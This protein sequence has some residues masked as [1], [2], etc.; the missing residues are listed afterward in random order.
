MI[1]L[2]EKNF[3][4]LCEELES[5][6]KQT[7]PG[8]SAHFKMASSHRQQRL[9]F[10]HDPKKAVE[11]AVLIHLYPYGSRIF[12]T[13]ILRNSYDGVHSGQVSFPGGGKEKTDRNLI[14]TALREAREEVNITPET[15]HILGVLSELYI[16]PSNYIVTP[17]VGFSESQPQFKPD[18]Y[19]V[20][21]IIKTDLSFLFDE[22]KRKEKMIHVREYEIEA[23]YFD[24]DGYVAW[25]ATAMILSELREVIKSIN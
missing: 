17:V 11:S 21:K 1:S 2:D 20:V 12:T 25:G 10:G 16:P 9:Q 23:P 7:L 5:K 14:E 3:F 4:R 18:N 13:L 15:V 6:L 24:V 8:D 19:E 22:S